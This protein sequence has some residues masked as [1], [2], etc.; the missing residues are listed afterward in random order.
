MRHRPLPP[1][2]YRRRLASERRQALAAAHAEA[3]RLRMAR[4]H[5]VAAVSWPLVRGPIRLGRAKTPLGLKPR[6]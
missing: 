4:I 6:V 1:H 3:R 2:L 5:M